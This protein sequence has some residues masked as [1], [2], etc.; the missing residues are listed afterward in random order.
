MRRIARTTRLAPLLGLLAGVSAASTAG[1]PALPAPPAQQPDRDWGALRAEVATAPTFRS[2]DGKATMSLLLEPKGQ[3]IYLGRGTFAPGAAIAPH[4]HDDS[5]ELV[6]VISGRGTLTIGGYR[7]PAWPG[8]AFRIPAGIEHSF[9]V[10]GDQPVEVV[11]VYSPAGPEQRFRSWE[12][13]PRPLPP[14]PK[15]GGR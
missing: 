5:D 8:T 14:P 10:D 12:A 9:Q 11:Q 4:R 7:L 6:Y 3:G 2:P 1:G 15:G 13:V